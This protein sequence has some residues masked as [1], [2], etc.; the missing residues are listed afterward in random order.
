MLAVRVNAPVLADVAVSDGL[1]GLAS[2]TVTVSE[3]VVVT[4][5]E[6]SSSA[7]YTYVPFAFPV[8]AEHGTLRVRRVAG[9]VL[10][11]DLGA[12]LQQ[13][14]CAGVLAPPQV[15]RD[16]IVTVEQ[17]CVFAVASLSTP[18]AGATADPSCSG[19][20]RAKR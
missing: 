20:P 15:H 9:Q 3:P 19:T 13:A 6:F 2:F 8:I 12:A 5:V 18:F 16:R 7:V 10:F 11:G 17:T 14:H 1:P 4:P